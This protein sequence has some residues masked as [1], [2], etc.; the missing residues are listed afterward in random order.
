MNILTNSFIRFH[1]TVNKHTAKHQ[2][3]ERIFY[4][5]NTIL[6]IIKM[7]NLSKHDPY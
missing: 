3:R 2:Y 4:I 6:I 7:A 1:T 5:I